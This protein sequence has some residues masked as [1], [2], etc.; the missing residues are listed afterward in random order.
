MAH[1]H[2]RSPI[3]TRA[4][5]REGR[6]PPIS[7]QSSS[8]VTSQSS[9]KDV[10][11]PLV[12]LSSPRSP[13]SHPVSPGMLYSRVVSPSQAPRGPSAHTSTSPGRESYTRS[14]TVPL[15]TADVDYGQLDSDKGSYDDNWTTVTKK[16]SRTHRE[17][18]V[19]HSS[20]ET[21]TSELTST[22]EIATHDMSP[23]NLLKLSHRYGQLA[24]AGFRARVESQRSTVEPQGDFSGNKGSV[25]ASAKS[26]PQGSELTPP[27]ES[28][29]QAPR[30]ARFTVPR[31][32]SSPE[33]ESGPSK[34]KGKGFDPRNWGAIDF[35]ENF[36][37]T[38]L[39]AQREAL[40]NFKEIRQQVKSE[41][42]STPVGFFDND[43]EVE[44]E[45]PGVNFAE[46]P[47]TVVVST[48]PRKSGEQ[49]SGQ[50]L[51]DEISSAKKHLKELKRRQKSHKRCATNAHRASETRK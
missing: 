48:P 15:L 39:N 40:E 13:R 31:G 29:P 5:V 36:S 9:G 50:S 7:R 41:P 17:R 8:S 12:D 2:G 20:R 4:A 38:E 28:T 11:G 22:V 25:P 34:N 37:E 47:P 51:S 49:N 6:I 44:P 21:N 3:P 42:K 23:E 26:A 30:M 27:I 18:T 16:T 35:S 19:S 24:A 32:E 14:E 1:M 33:V 45:N 43:F 46:S 10:S